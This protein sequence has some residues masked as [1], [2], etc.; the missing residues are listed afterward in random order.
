MLTGVGFT[1]IVIKPKN[2]SRAF[3]REWV[4]GSSVE[5]YVTSATI[6]AIKPVR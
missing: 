6:E 1:D 5:D 3:I 4:P 2:E